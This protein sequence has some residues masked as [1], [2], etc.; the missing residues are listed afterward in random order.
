MQYFFIVN[1]TAGGGKS[2]QAFARVTQILNQRGIEYEAVFTDAPGHATELARQAAADGYSCVVS[3]GG[4]GT[5]REVAMGLL[6]TGVTMGLLPFGTGNDFAQAAKIPTDPQQA[7]EVLLRHQI[8][9]VDT[10]TANGVPY[11]NFA[12]YGFDVDVV[13]HTER[14]KK[15]FR[16]MLPYTLGM[17]K[18]LFTLTLR[19]STITWPDGQIQRRVV[20]LTAANGTHLGGGMNTT[21]LA[22]ISD[23]L[24][25]VCVLHDLNW[26]TILLNF[27]TYIRGKHVGRTKH[28]TY[29]KTPTLTVETSIPSQINL[30]GELVGNTPVTFCAE[31]KSL[32]M[33]LGN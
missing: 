24:L 20:L 7:V 9:D 17:L 8:H 4:D 2:A 32:R 11:L 3:V 1:P 30:D 14:Y 16:G 10:A 33:I 21:P 26:F 25:D 19:P 29:F 15:K 6:H 27:P 5:A 23:G 22:D 18:A 28:F 13:I 12:G 31:P